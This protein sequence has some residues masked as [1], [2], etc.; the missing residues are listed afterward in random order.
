M[1]V[2]G[3]CV[4]DSCASRFD[5]GSI[6]ARVGR[7]FRP[8][9]PDIFVRSRRPQVRATLE[10]LAPGERHVFDAQLTTLQRKVVH[11]LAAELALESA[12]EGEGDARC[13]SVSRP[14]EPSAN[15]GAVPSLR[16]PPHKRA[17]TVLEW[18]YGVGAV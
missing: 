7:G 17:D 2:W 8:H 11:T 10:G 12:S 15:A 16:P 6:R 4:V 18:Y 9:V 1:F 3:Q 5:M 13:V 14:Q